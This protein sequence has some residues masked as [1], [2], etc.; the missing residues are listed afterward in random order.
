MTR[1][2]AAAAHGDGERFALAAGRAAT[3][4][5][6]RARRGAGQTAGLLALLTLALVGFGGRAPAEVE[7]QQEVERAGGVVEVPGVGSPVSVEAE[8]ALRRGLAYL[9]ERQASQ[10]DGSLPVADAQ[11]YAPV[12]VTALGALAFMA[13]GSSP[14]R[15]PYGQE[16]ARAVDHLLERA[17]LDP[18]AEAV[19]YIHAQADKV[20]RT[21]GHG[22]ATL[23][24]T[25]AF[26]SSP[27]SR[28]GE[29]LERVLVAAVALI[30]R[31]QGPEGGW[32]YEPRATV[33]HEG[34]VTIALVQALRG[35]RNAGVHVD[36]DVVA[37]ALS[38]VERS[39]NENGMF[40]YA[41]DLDRTSVAL[42]AAA[43]STLNALG[44]YD[45]PVVQRGMDAL[46]RELAARQSSERRETVQHP[47][48]E[49]FY[50]SQAL[51]FAQDRRLF[52]QWLPPELERV[53]AA[54]RP[55]GSWGDANYGSCYATA[56]NCLFLALPQELLPIFQR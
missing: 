10:R 2:F 16:V 26:A 51:W 25:Q 38:Y 14:E 42:T 19:G 32:Y 49:R 9:A 48:Y 7:G 43:L 4:R 29:R 30:E 50:L 36:T 34:S 20:S 13:G 45:G 35:A 53:L 28:R 15:G 17:D 8:E 12:A 6:N 1:R 5:A 46:W 33:Q 18:A 31:S 52:D 3:R 56:M 37:R 41:L 24:L 21:H 23:A 40:R 54:Q 11:Y 22:L 55:D 39:Q 47:F 44:E 27:R